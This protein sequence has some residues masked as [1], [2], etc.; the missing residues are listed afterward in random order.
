M[1]G[2]LSVENMKDSFFEDLEDLNT[3]HKY[4][5]NKVRFQGTEFTLL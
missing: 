4:S 1:A 2:L 5:Q 3:L